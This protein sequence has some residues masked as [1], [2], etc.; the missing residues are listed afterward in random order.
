MKRWSGSK[1]AICQQDQCDRFHLLIKVYRIRR[2][3]CTCQLSAIGGE[4]R[5]AREGLDQPVSS[6][7]LARL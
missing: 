7:K 5:F 2:Q 6:D 4:V 3:I 1:G